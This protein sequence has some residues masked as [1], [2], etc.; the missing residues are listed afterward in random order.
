MLRKA[1][2]SLA[3]RPFAFRKMDEQE[4]PH[5][6]R[7]RQAELADF[8]G[9]PGQPARIVFARTLDM[10]GVADRRDAGGDRRRVDVERSADA[11]DRIHHMGGAVHPAEAERG[12]AV[13]LREG[14][15]HHDVFRRR[16]Q[17]DA[18]LVVVALDV[19]GV[20]RVE[21]QQ[22]IRRQALVQPLD[23]VERN[24]GPGRIVGIGQEYD[25]GT[26]RH[27]FEDRVDIGGEILLRGDHGFGAGAHGR[28]RIDQKAMRG[29]DRLVAVAE[30][31]ARDQI[32]QVV[33]AGAADDARRIE[34]EDVADRLAQI[35]SR[36]VRII[37]QVFGHRAIGGDGARARP[38]RRLVG[39]QLEHLGD[40]RRIALAGHIGL[41]VEHAGARLRS[42]RGHSQPQG[43]SCPAQAGRPI[44]ADGRITFRRQPYSGS[45]GFRRGPP[46]EPWPRP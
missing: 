18:G 8:L 32:K 1:S 41:D 20:S 14:A 19:F 37:L 39:G 16:H 10:G 3:V 28:D 24:V 30:V 4:I 5:A 13:D 9:E 15:A 7:H 6:R 42:G 21:H 11:V 31:G 35:R 2:A 22:H 27:A 38:H 23:L 40:A 34:P 29:V 44:I 33:G 43:L 26:R 17:F 36:P 45:R 25:L 46:N 12:E